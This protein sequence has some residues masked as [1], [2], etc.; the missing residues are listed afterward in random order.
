MRAAIRGN[1]QPRQIAFSATEISLCWPEPVGPAL[2]TRNQHGKPA[3]AC[4]PMARATCR[5]WLWLQRQIMTTSCIATVSAEL[6]VKLPMATSW[7]LRWLVELQRPLPPWPEFSP[8]WNKKKEAISGKSITRCT[9]WPRRTAATLPHRPALRHKQAVFSTTSPREII[10]YHAL[11]VP[12]AALPRREAPTGSS[13]DKQPPPVL[14]WPQV[15][16]R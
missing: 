7:D 4:R 5:T 10:P 9:S 8:W 3:R 6:P 1:L 13:P 14:T 16:D 11:A 12:Q 2:F 15:S